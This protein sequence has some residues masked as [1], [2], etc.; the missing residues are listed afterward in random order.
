MIRLVAVSVFFLGA[1]VLADENGSF[2]LAAPSGW[3]GET[4]SLPPGFAPNMKLKGVE[5]IRFAPG[6]MQPESDSFFCYAFVFELAEKPGLTKAVVRDEFREYY[7]GLCTAVLRGQVPDVDPS[8]FTLQLKQVE[9]AATASDDQKTAT[10]YHGT[11]NWV[12]PFATKKP[13]KLNL[14]IRTWS[15]KGH[16]YLFA[17][18]S[19]QKKDAVIW[20]QLH[21]IRDGYLKKQ[22]TDQTPSE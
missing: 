12:E 8:K 13:Q 18:V 4:I 7:R 20:K 9:S 22:K 10:R 15:R 19:P 5:H 16:N 1:G 17:C 6:M 21:T 3:G 11:L 14:E 2:A